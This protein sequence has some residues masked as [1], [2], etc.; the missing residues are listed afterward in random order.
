MPGG[1]SEEGRIKKL[2][3]STP[4]HVL[5]LAGTIATLV[6][7]GISTLGDKPQAAP[8][9]LGQQ[10]A[11]STTTRI[12]HNLEPRVL[13]EVARRGFAGYIVSCTFVRHF[14]VYSCILVPK[15]R[16]D[17][18]AA[19]SMI[20]RVSTTGRVVQDRFERLEALMRPGACGGG[21]QL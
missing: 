12:A 2:L 7:F 6:A 21:P 13:G 18:E 19:L 8:P 9:L 14:S 10:V 3:A 16:G 20:V 17:C 15:G 4:L 11:G 1:Q 5:G